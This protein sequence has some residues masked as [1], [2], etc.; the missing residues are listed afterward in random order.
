MKRSASRLRHLSF[1][2]YEM[3]EGEEVEV[4]PTVDSLLRARKKRQTR[5]V[6]IRLKR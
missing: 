4:R 6:V 3:R 5:R 2:K 1:V